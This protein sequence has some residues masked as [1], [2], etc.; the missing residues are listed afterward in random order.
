[1]TSLTWD[2][3]GAL[4]LARQ[5]P[6]D[7]GADV[8]ETVRR[9]GPVQSQTARSPFLALAARRPGTTYAEVV[10]AHDDLALVR[11]SVVRGT[12]HTCAAEHHALLE[13]ATRLGRRRLWERVLRLEHTSLED[14]WA[15]I[16]EAARGEWRTGEELHAHL[17]TWLAAHGEDTT[18]PR[19]SDTQG[20]YLAFGHGGLLRRP[21]TGGW[22]GQGRAEYRTATALLGDRATALAD[23]H[24]LDGLVRMHL[25]A[26]GP[27]SR[28]DLAWWAGLT[29]GTVD[30]VLARLDLA[31][32]PGPDG[33]TYVDLPDAPPPTDLPGVRLLPE[34][35]ALMCAYEPSGR[36]RFLDQ[37]HHDVLWAGANGLVLPPLLVDGRITGWWR[38]AGRSRRRTLE[39]TWF[40]GT[41]R[42]RRSELTEPVAALEAALDVEVTDVTVTR[43]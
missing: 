12:V 35:D 37:S 17:L 24:V 10:A 36:Q 27:A 4:A 20:R 5:F 40:A 13:A 33:R 23:P 16:E 18:S 11:G 28:Q 26:H 29:L 41:R 31:G 21:R 9:V 19:L 30:A 2:E 34:F 32:V 14:V 7:P 8:A 38:A 3:L 6:D 42:P 39:V 1:M 15:G 22:E 25:A 43:A